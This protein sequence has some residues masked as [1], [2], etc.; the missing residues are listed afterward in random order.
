MLFPK[1]ARTAAAWVGM[2]FTLL[3]FFLYGPILISSATI[4]EMNVGENYVA[5]TLLYG[6]AVLLLASALHSETQK[7]S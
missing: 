6:G 7:G 3:T 1:Y 5:D 4:A 2:L